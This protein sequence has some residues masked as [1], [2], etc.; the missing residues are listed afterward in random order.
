MRSLNLPSAA[1]FLLQEYLHGTQPQN[2]LPGGL[3]MAQR[4][5]S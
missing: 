2:R 3:L 1:H 5:G 4:G